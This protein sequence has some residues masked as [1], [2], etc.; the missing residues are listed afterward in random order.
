MGPPTDTEPLAA[1]RDGGR[2]GKTA[3]QLSPH[4]D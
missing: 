1:E 2:A 4:Q 3:E